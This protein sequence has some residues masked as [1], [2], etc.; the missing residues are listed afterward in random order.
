MPLPLP[1]SLPPP[2]IGPEQNPFGDL[3]MLAYAARVHAEYKW[4]R[5]HIGFEAARTESG[6]A[7]I[8]PRSLTD[9]KDPYRG[10]VDAMYKNPILK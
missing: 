9:L 6:P 10:I 4:Y 2:H 5:K 8:I 1:P 3:M 7:T